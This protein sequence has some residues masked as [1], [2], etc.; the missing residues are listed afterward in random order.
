MKISELIK[1]DRDEMLRTYYSLPAEERAVLDREAIELIAP[2]FLLCK[3][4][5]DN[6]RY[7]SRLYGHSEVWKKATNPSEGD[8]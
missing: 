1:M 4:G 6:V 5:D 8:N 7:V 2:L 3:G